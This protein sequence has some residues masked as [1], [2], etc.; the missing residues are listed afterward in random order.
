MGLLDKAVAKAVHKIK[1]DGEYE[2]NIFIAPARHEAL[3]DRFTRTMMINA[4]WYGGN[5]LELKQLYERDL[6]SFKIGSFTSD[7]LNYFWAQNT[8]GTNVRKI[9][10]GIPQLISEKMVDLILANGYEYNVYKDDEFETRDDDNQQRLDNILRYNNFSLLLPEAIETESWAGGVAIK[11]SANTKY[12]YPIIEIIQPEEYEPVMEAGRIVGDIFVKYFVRNK[13]TYKLKEYYGVDEQGGFIRY[14]MYHRV[15]EEWMEAS[16]KDVKETEN[17]EDITF[18]GLFKKFSIYKPN[19]LPNSEFKGSKL[20][21]SDYSGSQGLFD[22]IDETLSAMV[23]E[24][25]DGKIKNFWPSNLLPTDPTTNQQYIPPALKKDFV[26]YKGGIGQGEQPQKIEQVQGEI[27]SDKHLETYKKLI[28]T[29]LNN[30]GLSPQSIGVTGLESVSASEE[31]QELREKT[32]IRTRE[33][34][35]DIWTPTLNEV[36]IL[37]LMLDDIKNGKKAGEYYVD[38]VFNDYKIETLKDKTL[39]AGQGLTSGTWDIKSAVDYV[40]EE[41]T[42]EEKILTRINIK[43]E[44]GITAFTKEEEIVYKKYMVDTEANPHVVNEDVIT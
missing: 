35:I 42:D 26:I 6:K 22:A 8:E 20:G 18:P 21:E 16:L 4:T 11:L 13:E 14:S 41:M 12:D 27:H 39:I 10:S 15:G 40:H 31:S 34:K 1:S 33:R 29:V 2:Y 30:S 17:L 3:R 28:E 36:F 19:K 5:D 25:R 43:I 37:L 23:Q 44:K 38:V 32:S 9:H 7:E 24:F